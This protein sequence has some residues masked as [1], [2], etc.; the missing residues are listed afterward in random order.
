M[1]PPWQPEFIAQSPSC[2]LERHKKARVQGSRSLE[3]EMPKRLKAMWTHS[4]GIWEEVA[5]PDVVGGSNQVTS[6]FLTGSCRNH[7][8]STRTD[9]TKS[10]QFHSTCCETRRSLHHVD[11]C[12]CCVVKMSLASLGSSCPLDTPCRGVSP[13]GVPASADP[14]ACTCRRSRCPL[15]T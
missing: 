8:V 13:H 6:M 1:R 5:S 2:T 12:A 4:Q 11:L 10:Q 9:L 14:P 15:A 3:R 7:E